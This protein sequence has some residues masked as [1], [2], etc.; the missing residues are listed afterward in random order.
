MKKFVSES[1]QEFRSIVEGKSSKPKKVVQSKED[2]AKEAIK[3]LKK[4]LADIEKPGKL[5][6]TKIQRDADI[7]E[8]KGKIAK[9][10]KKIKV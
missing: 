5:K 6:G 1:L 9:W 8:I 7:R 3:A 2:K 4:Q 10:E